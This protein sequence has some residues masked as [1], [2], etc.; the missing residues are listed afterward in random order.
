MDQG[1]DRSTVT[2]IVPARV[3]LVGNP[4]DGFGGAVLATLVPPLAATVT[5]TV[6]DGVSFD[7]ADELR[8]WSSLD[9]WLGGIDVSGHGDAQR[10][11]SAALLTVVDHLRPTG[12]VSGHGVALRWTT[13][14]PR[15]VGL[16]GSSA[17]AVG[18]IDA[19]AA[20]WG[21]DLDRRVVAALALRAE[22]DILGIAAGWQDRIVQAFGATV[23]ADASHLDVVDGI[24]VPRVMQPSDAGLHVLVGW[25][26]GDAASSDTYH[27]PLR[28]APELLAAPMAQ[29]ADLARVAADAWEHGDVGGVG[30]AIDSGW[31]I[32]QAC[33]P[34]RPDHAALVELV[35][36]AGVHATT[37][38]SG[39]SVVAVS[40]DAAA[41]A[42][43]AAA[44]AA[45][46]CRSIRIRR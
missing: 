19:T 25:S 33:A 34:L 36:A 4:S 8:S 35:R 42:A 7:G 31:S 44:L 3:G 9:D 32:R 21:V 23:L 28:R 2:R 29:L 37:P 22:R 10:L 5:A 30:D 27:A 6:A 14:V 16:A 1:V 43:A 39:G 41:L 17:L 11:I 12:R 18:V 46:G 45:H 38:G 24:E 13:T 20:A 40:D 26:I 15:S